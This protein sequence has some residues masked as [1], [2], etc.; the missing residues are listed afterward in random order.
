[1]NAPLDLAVVGAGA[2]GL[3]AAI[4]AGRTARRSGT[5]PRIVAFDGARKIGAKIL[6]SGGGRCN[7][8]HDPVDETAFAGSSPNAIRKVLRRF[9]GPQTID[10]FRQLGVELKRE[11]TGKLFPVTDDARTVLQAL[12][13]AA[14]DA[15]VEIRHPA[16]I[17]AVELIDDPANTAAARFRLSGPF[18]EVLARRVVLATGGRS[19][20]KTG[21]DGHGLDLARH[22][23]HT[24]TSLVAPALVPLLLHESC[25]IRKLSGLTVPA[26]LELRSGSGRRLL[27]LTDSMLCT[28]FGLSGPCVLDMSR[29]YRH[30]LADDPDAHL[31]VNWLPGETLNSVER[32]LVET[33][34]A[35]GRSTVLPW[36]S[37][38]IPRRLAAALCEHAGIS[39]STIVQAMTRPRRR[40]LATALTA[41]PL[42]VVGDRGWAHAEVTA[43]GVPLK[44]LHL[45][46]MESRIRPGLHVC[47]E[48]CDVDG[49]IGGYNFQWAWSSGYAAGTSAV[50]RGIAPPRLTLNRDS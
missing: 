33:A 2:A 50:S 11:E 18:G 1:M 30:A 3:M 16:R 29:H 40:A 35:P 15:G 43:G 8:A 19:Y 41:L 26:A 42:P 7:V 5:S 4:W 39:D 22:L 9:D 38:L 21:S 31:L 45:Q 27:T 10:F 12:L 13:A 20:P 23:G 49:R 37:K 28:H 36:L 6:I 44:E 25:F 17:D 32:Q 34:A 24:I 48:V 47:G 14:K 46:T